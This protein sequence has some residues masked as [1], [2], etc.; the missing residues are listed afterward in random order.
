MDFTVRQFD[1]HIAFPDGQVKI[2]ENY[3]NLFKITSFFL[4]VQ[5][6]FGVT[7]PDGQVGGKF[8]SYSLFM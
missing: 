5:V 4:S 3:Q 1:F 2:L 6:N 8:L 7:R